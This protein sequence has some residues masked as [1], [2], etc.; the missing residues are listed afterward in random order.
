VEKLAGM[1]A[2]AKN[3]AIFGGDGC[4]DARAEALALANKLKAPVGDSFRGKQWLE[5]D[6][7]NAVGMTGLLGYGGAYHAIY[8]ANLLLLVGTDFPFSEFLPGDSVKKVQIDRNP[9]HLWSK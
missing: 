3:V 2:D 5:H 7:P 9:K 6:N 4:R 1:I 8:D